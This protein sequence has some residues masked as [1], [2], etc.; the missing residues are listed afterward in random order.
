MPAQT[1][2]LNI[3]G[4]HTYASELSGVP[5]GALL[6][7]DDVNISRTNIAEPRRGFDFLGYDPAAE[8]KKLVFYNSGLFV[9]YNT[10]FGYNNSGFVNLGTL[11][12]PANATSIRSAA[13]SNNL[14]L[15]NSAGI[16]KLDGTTAANFYP[17]GIPKGTLIEAN[18][19]LSSAGSPTCLAAGKSVAYRYVLARKDNNKNVV[20][21]GVSARYVVTNN[22]AG[23]RDVPLKVYL[24]T[25]LNT[26]YYVQ[27][28]RT[29]ATSGTP[30]DEMQLCY[31]QV[32]DSTMVSNGYFIVL[33]IVPDDLLGATLYTSPSQQGILN[34]NA[35]PPLA[36]DI[37]EFKNHLFFADVTSKYRSTVTLVACGGSGVTSGVTTF[38]ISRSGATSEVYTARNAGAGGS[39]AVYGSVKFL[40]DDASS[41]LSTRIDTTARSLVSMINQTSLI[42]YAYLLSDGSDGLPGKILL[43]ERTFG[44][45]KFTIASNNTIAW[46]PSL[47]GSPVDATNDEFKNGLMYSKQYIPE[48][49]PLKNIVRVGSSDDRIKRIV[50][51]RDGLFI[52]KEKDGVYVLRGENEASFSVSLLD[53]TAKVKSADSLA[54]VNNLIYGLFDAGV[55]EVSD[56]GVSIIGL[57]IKDKILNLYGTALAAVQT[58]AF[59]IGYD[60]EGKYVLAMPLI[61]SDTSC[62]QQFVFDVYGRTW[63][64]WTLDMR[65]G[66]VDP[67]TGKLNYGAG[68]LAKIRVERKVYDFTDYADYG[69]TCTITSYTGTTVA[70]N[71]TASMAVGDLLVQG[72]NLAYIESINL[73]AGTV[74]IDTEQAWTLAT[75]NVDWLKAINCKIE[76]NAEAAGNP[77]GYK[78]FYEASLLL[79]QGFQKSA[80]VY[81]YSDTNPGESSITLSSASGNGAFGQ[82]VFG[83]EIW[84]GDP[85]KEPIRF[86]VPAPVSRCNQLSVRVENRVAY[87]DFQLEGISLIFNPISVRTAR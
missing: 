56:S 83:E 75:A 77:A 8:V 61:A 12:T 52:F 54:S 41:S 65:S 2:N 39:S 82:F 11:T 55:C 25:G 60:L 67:G 17:S 13:I 70:I 29:A 37:A 35:Q 68:G 42:C 9:H 47:S 34:D 86:G 81:F 44:N 64:R 84:G 87:S 71:N 1:I 26:S 24:P 50:A 10:T 66:G 7:A 76:W 6:T 79:K 22:T 53:S 85:V 27:L 30:N 14:Y 31:E 38:T 74:T 45:P 69:A 16:M 36:M 72:A 21:G 58:Y 73:A 48:S 18:G 63:C 43:E 15:T 80:T 32:L 59:G 28:Y 20:T 5:Q 4:L 3:K 40:V 49:V 78:Q 19:S 57:P 46:N 33:D 23:I 62:K 51:L